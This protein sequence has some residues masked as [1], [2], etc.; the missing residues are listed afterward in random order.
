M[1]RREATSPAALLHDLFP[2][3][4]LRQEAAAVGLV[5]RVRKVDVVQLF[6]AVVLTVSGRGG[7]TLAALRGV[8]AW[9]GVLT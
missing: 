8:G 4:L 7:Q 5:Q 1:T 9:L 3:S 2:A 6:L